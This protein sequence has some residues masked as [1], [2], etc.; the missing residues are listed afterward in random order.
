VDGLHDELI[1]QLAQIRA[2]TV[3]SRTSVLIVRQ[4]G[5]SLPEIAR[6]LSADVVVEG[7]VRRKGESWHVTTQLVSGRDDVHL[8]AHS[9]ERAPPDVPNLPAEIAQ[10]V[11]R[12]LRVRVTADERARLTKTQRL[13][14]ELYKAYQRAKYHQNKWTPDGLQK[15]VGFYREAI[16]IDP[17]FA[18]A[19][20]GL[21]QTY[22]F[23]LSFEGTQADDLRDRAQAA[24]LRALQFDA[25]LPVPHQV[26]GAIKLREW[27]W[28]GAARE[29]ER[30][31][32]LDL[33]PPGYPL[34]LLATGQFDDAVSTTRR[35]AELGPL[36]YSAHLVAGWTAFM[37]GRYDDAIVVL[38][39]A[40]DLDP[41]APPPHF[42]L[43]WCY[44]RKGRHREATAECDKALALVRQKQPTAFVAQGCEWVYAAAGRRREALE[45][46]QRIGADSRDG[47]RFTRVAHVYDALGEREQALE[48]LQK[49]YDQKSPSLPRQ[50]YVPMLSDGIKTD[51]LFQ[52]L[53]RQTGHPWAR[54]PERRD[55]LLAPQTGPS[56]G[57]TGR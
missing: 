35:D 39:K 17:V 40:M 33:N 12:Q 47:A 25:T 29:Y 8:W 28:E 52:Q 46:A 22:F 18:P 11:A 5:K 38:N 43:A 16:D 56:G 21:A 44:T 1:T 4:A 37:A 42:E 14:P 50:W 27:D 54:F 24:A 48:Y 6:E 41:S 3:V 26:L 55:L 45:F 10:A 9:Y 30:A 2:L 7:S 20:A 57:S 53:I 49:A 36:D 31:G 51:P 15:A 19:W 13:D 32:K 34:Y 23:N